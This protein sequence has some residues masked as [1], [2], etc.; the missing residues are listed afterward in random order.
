MGKFIVVGHSTTNDFFVARF[1]ST[2]GLDSGAGGFGLADTGVVT[3]SFSAGNDLANS[4]VL[5]SDGKIIAAGTANSGGGA[6]AD[7]AMARYDS[8][9]NLDTNA[10]ADPG[11]VFGSGGKVTTDF[12]AGTVSR[13][14]V[15]DFVGLTSTGKVIMVGFSQGNDSS[16][17]STSTNIS[18]ARYDSMGVLDPTFGT[19]GKV[20]NTLGAPNLVNTVGIHG[21]AIQSDNKILVGGGFNNA[22]QS[23]VDF[24]VARFSNGLDC[25]ITC[26][27][28][29]TQSNDPGQ[30][31][32]VV[33][34]TSPTETGAQCGTINC[35]PASG[36]FFPVG[37]TTV[38]CTDSA[39]PSC[40]FTVTVNDTQNPTITCPSNIAVPGSTCQNVSYTTPSVAN[41][42]VSDNCPG[43]TASCLPAS[44]FCFPVG[45]TTVTCTATDASM[46]MATCTFTVTVS[47]CTITCPANQT[48]STGPGATQCCATV[49]YPAPTADPGCG[50]VSCSPASGSC[51][52]VGTTTVNCTTTAGPSCAFTV[53][54]TDNTPPVITGPGDIN[55]AG[56]ASCPIATTSGPVSFM[57]TATDNCPGVT[58][59][60]NPPSGSAFPAGTTAVTC[61][62]TDASGNMAT[63]AFNVNVFSFCLQDDSIPGNVVLVN[64]Q[65]GDFFFCCGGV[66]I[67]SGRGTLTT[68]GC[69]GSIDATKGDRQVH[70]QWDTAANNNKGAG[71]AYV[72]KLSNKTICQ[73]TDKNLSNNT[74][75]CSAAPQV[76]NPKKPPKERDL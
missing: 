23:S 56:V 19:G 48:A 43:A 44:G 12:S 6:A 29:K 38:T 31:G 3:T 70:I 53:T 28:N 36:S 26:P 74:C 47:N 5:Q 50:T 55:A 37:T 41:G 10:D 24:L 35:S 66:P 54:V 39:G 52:P 27:A 72:Q 73:I 40:S 30:C 68:H 15:G 65:T 14:E 32:A 16:D 49:T 17:N 63:C 64:A 22:G 58:T 61:K 45:T 18:I 60:C 51:F 76:V 62:A 21:G 11:V 25:T 1:T 71:T 7:F 46:N 34:Y 4:V 8:D 9:G 75:Q 67:A 42:K 20:V 33:T 13:V 59:I 2:G 69:I 57:V